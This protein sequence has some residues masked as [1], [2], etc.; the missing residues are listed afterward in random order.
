[1]VWLSVGRSNG[2]KKRV[3]SSRRRRF[4][5]LEEM[6]VIYIKKLFLLHDFASDFFF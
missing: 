3:Q 4:L 6:F 5:L 1:M 2:T